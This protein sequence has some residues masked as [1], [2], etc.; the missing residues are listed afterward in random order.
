M[1]GFVRDKKALEL[2]RA[3][4]NKVSSILNNTTYVD[5]AR[6]VIEGA[7]G[8]V[9]TIHYSIKEFITPEPPITDEV[10]KDEEG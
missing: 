2:N 10:I 1:N 8:E 4:V 5:S 7:R 6:I 3:I 9:T